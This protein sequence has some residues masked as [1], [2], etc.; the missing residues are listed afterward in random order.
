MEDECMT[1]EVQPNMSDKSTEGHYG[2]ENH[3]RI[4]FALKFDE[5]DP[6]YL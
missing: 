3:D 1:S 5:T 6:D 2:T 4:L